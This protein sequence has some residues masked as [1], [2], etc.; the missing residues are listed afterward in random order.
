[1]L[2]LDAGHL[3]GKVSLDESGIVPFESAAAARGHELGCVVEFIR[4]LLVGRGFGPVSGEDV[5][6][7]AT[8][9]QGVHPPNLLV[10]RLNDSSSSRGACQPPC[11]KPPSVSSSGPPGACMTP[12][13]VTNSLTMSWP[14]MSLRIRGNPHEKGFAGQ[15]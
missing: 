14:M 12:S 9:E 4:D 10:M 1:M 8:Q 13:R 6:G 7:L 2:L 3:L 15:G 11:L 5:V